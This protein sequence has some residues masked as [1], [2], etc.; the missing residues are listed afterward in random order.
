MN[1]RKMVI[2]WKTTAMETMILKL[3]LGPAEKGR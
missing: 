2:Y 1:K 3:Y